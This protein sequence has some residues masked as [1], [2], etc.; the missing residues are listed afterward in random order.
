MDGFWG[1]EEEG[2][3]CGKGVVSAQGEVAPAER[4]GMQELNFGC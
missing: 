3:E 2:E 1:W 4:S